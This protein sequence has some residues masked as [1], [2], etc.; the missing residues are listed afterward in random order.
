MGHSSLSPIGQGMM[1]SL[2]QPSWKATGQEGAQ[3]VRLLPTTRAWKASGAGKGEQPAPHARSVEGTPIFHLWKPKKPRKRSKTLIPP[4]GRKETPLRHLR[5]ARF[6][7]SVA[8]GA[9]GLR[10]AVKHA[11]I[12]QHRPSEIVV[13]SKR[14]FS[15]L[16]TSKAGTSTPRIPQKVKL[17]QCQSRKVG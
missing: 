6:R 2:V 5:S 10:A 7:H 1:G 15:I 8:K 12:L 13:T 9:C 17:K 3:P 14:R 11:A 4:S 16:A